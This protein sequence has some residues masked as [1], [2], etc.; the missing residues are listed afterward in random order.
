[1][2]K[3]DLKVILY[4]FSDSQNTKY[5]FAHDAFI[6]NYILNYC[7]FQKYKILNIFCT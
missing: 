7:L 2:K 4:S 5:F 3:S 6:L 1:M